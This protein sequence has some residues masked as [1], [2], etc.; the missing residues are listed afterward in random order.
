MS[1]NQTSH[2]TY[3]RRGLGCIISGI[4]NSD[5]TSRLHRRCISHA[6]IDS[7]GQFGTRSRLNLSTILES[8][9]VSTL[10]SKAALG[11]TLVL[12]L[13]ED[14]GLGISLGNIGV[15]GEIGRYLVAASF[16]SVRRAAAWRWSS[17]MRP[18]GSRRRLGEGWT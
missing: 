4:V 8:I 5:S 16:S 13:A 3:H 17:N 9:V 15:N 2:K 10:R 18:R 7:G 14:A 12:T 6:S 1:H 11:S